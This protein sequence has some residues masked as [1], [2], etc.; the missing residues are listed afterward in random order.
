M[1]G[2]RQKLTSRRIVYSSGEESEGMDNDDNESGDDEGDADHVEGGKGDTEEGEGNMM[3]DGEE[4]PESDGEFL[5]DINA[6]NHSQRPM[7]SA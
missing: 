7:R 5:R 1:V 4:D 6:Q 3:I 2:A